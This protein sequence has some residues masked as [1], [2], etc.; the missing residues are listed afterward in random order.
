MNSATRFAFFVDGCNLMG[1]LKKL[2]P[3]G[4]VR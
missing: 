2:G 1:S 3:G 4:Q